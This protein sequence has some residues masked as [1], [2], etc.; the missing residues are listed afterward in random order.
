MNTITEMKN[1][2]SGI[3]SRLLTLYQAKLDAIKLNITKP[4]HR[5]DS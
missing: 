5:L 1:T 2:L 4:M 3:N